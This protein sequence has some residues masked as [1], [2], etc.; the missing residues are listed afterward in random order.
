VAARTVRIPSDLAE[1]WKAYCTRTGRSYSAVVADALI[2]YRDQMPPLS[3]LT[4]TLPPF[5]A[6]SKSPLDGRD[7]RLVDLPADLHQWLKVF[8]A[9]SG[10]T[11]DWVVTQ[12]LSEFRALVDSLPLEPCQRG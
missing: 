9:L 8:A 10:R 6:S 1:W 7:T 3:S 4:S 2:D 11:G 12:A 5:Q